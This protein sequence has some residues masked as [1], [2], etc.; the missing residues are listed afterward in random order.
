M[1]A[2]LAPLT[3]S[4]TLYYFLLPLTS[5]GDKLEYRVLGSVLGGVGMLGV[6]VVLWVM[7]TEM[8]EGEVRKRGRGK[9][10]IKG[11]SKGTSGKEKKE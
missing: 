4:F 3:I 5:L 10:R 11:G 1:N 7:R 8:R 6:E 2:I 9:G